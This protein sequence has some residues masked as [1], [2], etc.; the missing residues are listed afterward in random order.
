[1]AEIVDILERTGAKDYTRTQ[2]RL[3]RDRALA[4]LD[5][6]GVVLPEARARLEEI[7]VRVI[8]A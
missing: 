2:A 6:A 7:I 4:E 5:A 3:H 8:A 1:V